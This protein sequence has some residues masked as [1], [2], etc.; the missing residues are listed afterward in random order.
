M[1]TK[2]VESLAQI[3]QSL[4]PEE[5]TLLEERLKATPKKD[6]RQSYQELNELRERIFA[7]R[8]GQPLSPE[9]DEIIWQMREERTAEIMQSL[10]D[11]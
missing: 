3:I 9:P 1:N 7:R 2:L 10:Q 8:D 4:A 11:S 5:Q 6:W